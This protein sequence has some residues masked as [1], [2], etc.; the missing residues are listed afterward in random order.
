MGWQEELPMVVSEDGDD[1]NDFDYIDDEVRFFGTVNDDRL[2]IHD[3]VALDRTKRG[4]RS[5]IGRRLCERLRPYFSEIVASGVG[6]PFYE[7]RMPIPEQKPFLFWK[8]MLDEGLI[9][10]IIPFEGAVVRRE[11]TVP[12]H[13]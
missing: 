5:G 10:E 3:L 9:D 6:E 4:A 8:S 12:P 13:P 7:S 1:E 11:T 2:V